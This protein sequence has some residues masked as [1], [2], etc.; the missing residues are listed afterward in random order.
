MVSNVSCRS[1]KTPELHDL[2]VVFSRQKCQ[3][4]CFTVSQQLLQFPSC[5]P[6]SGVMAGSEC[7]L[8]LLEPVRN[9][10]TGLMLVW[11]V[12]ATDMASSSPAALP[13]P[14]PEKAPA[15]PQG[16]SAP[17]GIAC[18]L[19]HDKQLKALS[20]TLFRAVPF[21]WPKGSLC[22][23]DH[24]TDVCHFQAD[25]GAWLWSQGE[26]IQKL[27]PYRYYQEFCWFLQFQRG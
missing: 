4:L 26:G 1:A 3:L 18:F 9:P 19:L 6:S 23:C 10:V 12:T 25:L 14:P 16:H 17:V 11:P 27:L 24:R 5:L 2:Q 15:A 7:L 22:G 13:W 20:Q 21:I 8:D